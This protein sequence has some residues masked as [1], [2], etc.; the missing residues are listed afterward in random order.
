MRR[1]LS[2]C[3]QI[4]FASASFAAVTITSVT[5]SGGPTTGGTEVIIRGTEFGEIIG[6]PPQPP[7]VAFGLTL[8]TN[9]ALIDDTTIRAITPAHLP[10]VVDVSVGSTFGSATLE[11]VH[12]RRRSRRR[13]FERLLV[14]ILLPP[15]QGAYGSVFHT[16]LR[17]DSS[18]HTQRRVELMA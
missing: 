13:Y 2:F 1:I 15:V 6:S 8:A 17:I 9:V 16:E 5:P 11:R 4:V 18:R 7:G 10:G 12:V 3:L 14:P